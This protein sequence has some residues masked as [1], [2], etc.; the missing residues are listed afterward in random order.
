MHYICIT[1]ALT[2]GLGTGWA[3]LN[4]SR[5]SWGEVAE[6][7]E[8]TKTT[9]RRLPPSAPKFSGATQFQNLPGT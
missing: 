4:G 5:L 9:S 7:S 6:R 1:H 8:H 3:G 2:A